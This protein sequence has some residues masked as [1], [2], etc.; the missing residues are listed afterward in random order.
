MPDVG[1][2]LILDSMQSGHVLWLLMPP[3][4]RTGSANLSVKPD[5]MC[6]DQCWHAALWIVAAAF[7]S[8]R[9]FLTLMRP[10]LLRKRP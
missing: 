10:I 2:V 4:V 3:L 8:S 1:A 7:R 5:R 9:F 6:R